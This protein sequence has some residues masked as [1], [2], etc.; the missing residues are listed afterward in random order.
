MRKQYGW[1]TRGWGA[2]QN[3]AMSALIKSSNLYLSA[4]KADGQPF[5]K[6]EPRTL[7]NMV[8][9]G[10]YTP[11]NISGDV[12]LTSGINYFINDRANYTQVGFLFTELPFAPVAGIDALQ[13]TFVVNGWTER[14]F[15]SSGAYVPNS[16]ATRA[17]SALSFD[18]PLGTTLTQAQ[19]LLA[20]TVIRYQL[21]VPIDTLNVPFKNPWTDLKGVV[22]K[23]LFD[24]FLELGAISTVNGTNG[25]SSTNTRCINFL[26]VVESTIYN[27]SYQNS[28]GFRVF[29]YDSN[30]TYI[31]F[32]ELTKNTPFT[33]PV[34][35]KFLR[36]RLVSTNLTEQIQL[37]LGSTATAYEP[38]GKANCLLQA[39]AGT[40]ADGWT[41]DTAP[42][43]KSVTGL[44][45]DGLDSYGLFGSNAPNPLGTQDFA[46]AFVFKTGAIGATRCIFS[47]N[48]ST[49][50]DSQ[51]GF[52]ILTDG[53]GYGYIDGSFFT[54]ASTVKLTADTWYKLV[55][56]RK[57]GRLVCTLSNVVT[58]DTPNNQNITTKPNARLF[59]RSTNVG[60][61]THA[62]IFNGTLF[63]FGYNNGQ[64]IDKFEANF[65]KVCASK[66]G[67]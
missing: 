4:D 16:F 32:L 37:E 47:K 49:Q 31:S 6:L 62:N 11:Q 63:E 48:S 46:F 40:T 19:A 3:N 5:V 54:F 20:G 56:K 8:S 53:T 28:D 22:G 34:N 35:A 1:G 9:N 36:F 42:N 13:G 12:V 66:Y 58:T 18:F 55:V 67:L 14:A 23:N 45:G 60:G 52:Y 15:T 44:K 51:Y 29:F 30:K 57:N 64:D 2:S 39:F 38:Y 43:G 27:L 10:E 21:A 61:T 7:P 41:T 33:T 17:I 26:G 50:E 65:N 59:A 24:G 25:I